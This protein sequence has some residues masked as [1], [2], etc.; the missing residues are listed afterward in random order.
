MSARASATE[1]I[2]S[3]PIILRLLIMLVLGYWAFGKAFAYVG[4]YPLF[5]GEIVLGL[6]LLAILRY[7]TIPVPRNTLFWV[8]TIM[9]WM[10]IGQAVY[11]FLVLGQ[12]PVE[13][14]R[15][16]AMVYYGLFAYITFVIIERTRSP[17]KLIDRFLTELLPRFAPWILIGATVTVVGA[18][19]V[20]H[21]LPV[22]PRT[23]VPILWYK[24]TDSVVPL[25]VIIVAWMRGY[26]KTQY[27]V[28]AASLVLFAIARSR[29][30][31]LGVGAAFLLMMWRPTKRMLVAI[32]AG[33][34]VFILL[35]LTDVSISMGYREV[36]AR[37]FMANAISLVS[38]DEASQ[39]DQTTGE[40]TSWRLDWWTA[41]VDDS[42]DN[43]RV[44]VGTGWGDNL[45]NRYGF[46]IFN[47]S[48]GVNVLRN[49]H[50]AFI[51]ILARG[52][53]ILA[54]LW[55][56]FHVVLFSGLWQAAKKA[57]TVLRRDIAWVCLVYL[58]VSMINGS[59]DVYLESPQIAIPHWIVIGV[60]WSLI[61]RRDDADVV[62]DSEAVADP[63]Q[64]PAGTRTARQ[65]APQPLARTQRG[66]GD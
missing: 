39:I 36:S 50:N 7:G 62:P 48:E 29:S 60:T 21:F 64:T 43:G 51:N 65:P 56:L 15:G 19:Y 5:I 55:L 28:W 9:L 11:S 53:W 58:T 61:Y 54:G 16:L 30:A 22:F 47:E 35:L 40:N 45:A 27:A 26:L 8:F 49:P 46:Q 20:D 24:P 66:A 4:L 37:Q 63:A 10:S 6:G 41:I 44:F 1:H 34:L 31:M 59:T 17:G 32:L 33:I 18:L 52:G 57:P 42:V 3:S 12:P 14:M 2:R 23:D 38:S 13:V 25:L